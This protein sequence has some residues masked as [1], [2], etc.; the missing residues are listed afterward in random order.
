M[1]A[2]DQLLIVFQIKFT[3]IYQMKSLKIHL[4]I[5]MLLIIMPSSF[6]GFSVFGDNREFTDSMTSINKKYTRELD[7]MKVKVNML[8]CWSL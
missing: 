2:I 5:L 6:Q 4:I 1:I 7:E 3:T 8:N